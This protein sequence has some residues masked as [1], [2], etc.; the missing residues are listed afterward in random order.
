MDT[1]FCKAEITENNK[2]LTTK[3]NNNECVLCIV[4]HYCILSYFIFEIVV[5][6]DVTDGELMC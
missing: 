6:F 5:V 2:E 1:P 4:N 3:V